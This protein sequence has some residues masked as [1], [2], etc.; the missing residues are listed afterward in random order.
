[1]CWDMALCNPLKINRSLEDRKF[2]VLFHIS[3]FLGQFLALKMEMILFRNV[4]WLSTHHTAYILQ[5]GT[6]HDDRYENLRVF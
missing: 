6:L 2:F 5:H 4:G 1:M 3:Y